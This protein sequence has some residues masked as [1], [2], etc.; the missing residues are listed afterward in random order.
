MIKRALCLKVSGLQTQDRTN[1]P[2]QGQARNKAG[3]ICSHKDGHMHVA[4]RV[5]AFEAPRRDKV[6]GE[7]VTKDEH[8]RARTDDRK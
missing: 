5:R 8:H 7:A 1:T 4:R 2:S 3:K 6:V